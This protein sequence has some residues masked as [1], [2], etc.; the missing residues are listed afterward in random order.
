[1]DINYKLVFIASIVQFVLGAIWYSPIL[2]GKTWMQIMECTHLSKE[3]L[4]KMQKEMM[5]FYAL[6]LFLTFFMTVSLAGL[7]PYMPE[8]SI[9][10][11]GFWIWIGF[12]VPT[13]VGAVIWANTK[14]KYWLKQ[15][16][17]MS[18]FAFVA[19]MVAA[20]ILSA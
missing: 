5:P 9:Y 13:Q 6:Q 11:V 14:R 2:F 8:F 20:F 3:E 4:K 1:M 19:V 18:G 17:I 7:A 15:I 16:F 10:H 12:V